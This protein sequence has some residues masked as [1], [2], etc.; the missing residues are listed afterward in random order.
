[1]SDGLAV[2]GSGGG[3]VGTAYCFDRSII[4]NVTPS[5]NAMRTKVVPHIT[6]SL[7]NPAL[8]L[9]FTVF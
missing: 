8:L 3:A 9:C 6:M 2:M 5:P 1:M 7:E 4:Y